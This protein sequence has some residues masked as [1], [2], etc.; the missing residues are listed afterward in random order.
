[1]RLQFCVHEIG[2]I[3]LSKVMCRYRPGSGCLN[4]LK[5]KNGIRR[6][7]V[8]KASPEAALCMKHQQLH[9]FTPGIQ[10]CVFSFPGIYNLQQFLFYRYGKLL[11]EE[12]ENIGFQC[13]Q[14]IDRGRLHYLMAHGYEA[15]ILYYVE[16]SLTLENTAL[17][18][19][20]TKSAVE[21]P[22]NGILAESMQKILVHHW[23]W[24][25]CSDC[26]ALEF[27]LAHMV[28][29]VQ[30]SQDKITQSHFHGQHHR[31]RFR[32]NIFL[33]FCTQFNIATNVRRLQITYNSYAQYVNSHSLP[34][35]CNRLLLQTLTA[36]FS[37][38]IQL[39]R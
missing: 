3:K 29:F 37:T 5:G 14:V 26:Y 27:C 33:R 25:N 21:L 15:K 6:R 1:M 31:S 32:C 39:I 11:P 24:S 8:P 28:I 38:A 2:Y 36:V 10:R 23:F 22:S 35:S 30:Y 19:V 9:L 12:R 34:L 20:H 13:K 7:A 18:A 17:V 16:P 4:I